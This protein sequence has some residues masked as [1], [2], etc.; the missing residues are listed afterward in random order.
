MSGLIRTEA[1]NNIFCLR[2]MRATRGIPLKL[3]SVN[4]QDLKTLKKRYKRN[5]AQQDLEKAAAINAFDEKLNSFYD[6]CK[7]K[8]YK[9]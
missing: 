9:C 6:G 3:C 5:S 7:F 4:M 8:L 1:K 2:L